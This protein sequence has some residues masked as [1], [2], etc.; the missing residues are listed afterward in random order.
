M[1]G[2]GAQNQ[3]A[4]G[5]LEDAT[6]GSSAPRARHGRRR[7]LAATI[8]VHRTGVRLRFMKLRLQVMFAAP[9]KPDFA[10][11]RNLID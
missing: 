7:R 1:G 2:V 4:G 8:A 5:A 3:K 6:A 11:A 9:L 10:A